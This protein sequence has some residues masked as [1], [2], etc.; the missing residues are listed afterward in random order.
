MAKKSEDKKKGVDV[1]STIKWVFSSIVVLA[2]LIT[3]WKLIDLGKD[4]SGNGVVGSNITVNSTVIK[5]E[6]KRQE[7][8]YL[9]NTIIKNLAIIKKILSSGIQ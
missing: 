6:L 3:I 9:Q 8:L 7:S 2:I 5:A 1:N 4:G